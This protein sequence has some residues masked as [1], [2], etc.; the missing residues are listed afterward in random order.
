MSSNSGKPVGRVKPSIGKK[1]GG[2]HPG[3]KN[4]GQ[5]VKGGVVHRHHRDA[6][7]CEGP[8]C[9]NIVP[10]GIVAGNQ[11]RYFCSTACQREFHN[12]RY[13]LG[14]CISCGGTIWGQPYEKGIRKY[15]K[16]QCRIDH[17][18]QGLIGRTGPFREV[19][20]TYL[21]E[22]DRQEKS[23]LV[24]ARTSLIHFFTHVHEKEGLT[25]LEEIR[26]SVVSRFILS[27]RARGMKTL[28]SISHLS[29]FFSQLLIDERVDMSSPVIPRRHSAQ[30]S[31]IRPRPYSNAEIDSLWG[32][33]VANGDPMLM[34]AFQMGL[35]CGMRVGEVANA[36]LENVDR[37]K[38]EIFI[39][40]PTKNKTTRTVRFHDQVA[41][42][43]DQW[44][45]VRNS[46]CKHDH[47][48]H[49]VQGK[50][51]DSGGLCVQFRKLF[52]SKPAPANGFSFHR[53]RHTWA[54]RLVNN[55]MELP[56]LQELGGWKSLSSLQRYI[57]V[58][59]T[60]IQRQYEA[61][62]RKLQEQDQAEVEETLSLVDFAVI[63]AADTATSIKTAA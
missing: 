29:T 31:A 25:K 9:S 62:Y 12:K 8:G 46:L 51:F 34:L 17:K 3:K 10:A 20:E 35:E 1:T 13:D 40:L 61:S 15:C 58:L 33:L 63:N 54:T 36:G 5:F 26:P 55:G 60:T 2:K 28:N 11:K 27:E 39:R 44:L 41:S 52:N 6:G 42:Q 45:K 16:R 43:L 23:T 37:E 21:D 50:K 18:A 7:K 59:D 57:K 38:Q 14:P 56:I 4:K 19:I 24:G 53:L 49:S 48:L 32:H 22:D 30:S 47:L